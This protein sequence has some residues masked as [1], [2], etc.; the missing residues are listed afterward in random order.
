[1]EAGTVLVKD[2]N[3]GPAGSF[4]FEMTVIDGRLFFTAQT[5]ASGRELWKTDGS[6]S[7]TTLVFEIAPGGDSS[8]LGSVTPPTIVDV[9]KAVLFTA[10]DG[11]SGLEL[12]KSDTHGTFQLQDIA[13]GAASSNPESMTVTEKLVFFLANDNSSGR[14]LWVMPSNA[15]KAPKPLKDHGHKFRKS[16][17]LMELLYAQYNNLLDLEMP[18]IDEK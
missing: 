10:S 13:P 14:E 17:D 2:I 18:E 16:L 15:A 7:D 5:A 11:V 4:P 12:W 9:G 1:M 6:P 8:R 3:P